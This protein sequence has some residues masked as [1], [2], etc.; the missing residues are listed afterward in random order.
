M[1]RG[2]KPRNARTARGLHMWSCGYTRYQELIFT[3]ALAIRQQRATR[4]ASTSYYR[5]RKNTRVYLH[6]SSLPTP[7]PLSRGEHPSRVADAQAAS[8]RAG[9]PQQRQ[10]I[11]RK[12][13]HTPRSLRSRTFREG[14][15]LTTYHR[16]PVTQ[17]SPRRPRH[18]ENLPA[19]VSPVAGPVKRPARR[20]CHGGCGTVAK[21]SEISIQPGT[22]AFFLGWSQVCRWYVG[23]PSPAWG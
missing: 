9:D 15:A 5:T 7:P 3:L 20:D 4:R 22:S 21:V 8:R 16:I 1:T 23:V 12:Q 17:A 11:Q 14:E 18:A 13:S 2:G 6:P 10:P 19:K